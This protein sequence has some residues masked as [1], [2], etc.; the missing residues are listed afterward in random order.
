M[1]KMKKTGRW[2]VLNKRV[3]IMFKAFCILTKIARC[4][5]QLYNK[6]S[7]TLLGSKL[8]FNDKKI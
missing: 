8:R 3:R 7:I 4:C 1:A 5:L 2:G 6:E